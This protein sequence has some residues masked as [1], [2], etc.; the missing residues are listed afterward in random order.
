ML[1]QSSTMHNT[2]YVV[3]V[4]AILLCNNVRGGQCVHD[5]MLFLNLLHCLCL[6]LIILNGIL[7]WCEWLL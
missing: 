4:C 3:L 2:L 6:L 1:S 7:K 5:N